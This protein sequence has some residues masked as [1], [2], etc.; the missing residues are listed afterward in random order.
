MNLRDYQGVACD[1]VMDA[2]HTAP[3]ALLVMATGTGKTVV[4]SEVIARWGKGRV[5]VLAHRE[6]LLRQAQE[7]IERVL[8][9]GSVGLEMAEFRA[10]DRRCVLAS[11]QTLSRPRR[12]RRFRPADFGL[13]VTDE[14]HHAPA[15][16]YRRV[17]DY[18]RLGCGADDQGPP[19]EGNPDVRHLGVTATPN[20]ADELALGR[21][22]DVCAFE[23]GIEPAVADG[24]LV[25]VRQ[26]AIKVEGLD[27]SSVRTTAG[28]LN[29][30]D[31]EAILAQEEQLH[32][33][34]RPTVDLSGD[35]PTLVFAVTVNHARLLAQLLDRYKRGSALALSGDSRPEE[36]RQAVDDFRSGRLQYL[37]N[38]GLFLEGFDAPDTAL[39]VMARPT[40]SLPLYVQVL[41]RG[42]RPLPGV[43]DGL[44][45]APERKVAIA[46]SQKPSMLVLDF[47][48]NSGRHK[49][50]TAADVLG[51]K[52]GD[53][54]RRYAEKLAEQEGEAP[55]VGEALEQAADELALLEEIR[56]RERRRAVVAARASYRAESVSPFEGGAPAETPSHARR[57][58]ITERQYWFLVK[59]LGWARDS[60]NRLS[61]RQASAVISRAKEARQA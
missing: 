41:G 43:V 39:V 33:V 24:W 44:P 51:G 32:K 56:E 21:V 22:Y 14:A 35:R 49:I 6:E 31:L 8:G 16:T 52:Y 2:F 18:F 55:A 15:E 36:R 54:V 4:F 9:P 59:R 19:V 42:T 7:K 53:P 34:V 1:A 20:R 57:E 45:T 12:L 25:P 47:V 3:G 48:G 29:E 61:K 13:I 17:Y 60:A 38:C 46:A 37:C 27:F 10:A 50:V 30:A 23:Y 28:D 58:A 26:K 11:V 5:L 40:K